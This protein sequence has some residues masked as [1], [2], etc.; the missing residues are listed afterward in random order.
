MSTIVHLPN[1]GKVTVPTDDPQEAAKAAQ[2]YWNQMGE[3][4][5]RSPPSS[6]PEGPKTRSVLQTAGDFVG[7]TIDNFLPNWGDEIA[8][9]PDAAAA[10]MRGQ[11]V[12]AAFDQGRADFRAN[13]AQYDKEHPWLAWGSTLTGLGASLALPAGR[14]ASGAGMAAKMA[15]GAAVGAGYGAVAGAGQGDTFDQRSGNAMTGALVGGVTGGAALPVLAG[16][17]GAVRAV[18]RTVPGAAAVGRTIRNV[19]RSVMR[20]PLHTRAQQDQDRANR[21]LAPRLNEGNIST[22]FGQQGPAASP[23]NLVDELR[24]RADIGVPAMLADTTETLRGVTSWASRGAGPGQTLVKEALSR[25]KEAEANRV[26]QH[27][28]DNLGDAVDPLAQMR[29]HESRA[30]AEV[31]PLYEEAYAQPVVV[32]DTLR[33]LHDTPAFRSAVPQAFENIQNAQ[34]NPF[35]MGFH[36]MPDGTVAAGPSMT[37]EAYDQIVRAMRDSGRRAGEVN[38]LT[39]K[40][41]DTT[42]SIHINERAADLRNELSAQNGAYRDAQNVYADE[43]GM[44][45][46]LDRGQAMPK[47]TGSEVRAI[48]EGLRGSARESWAIGARSALADSASTWGHEH[49]TGSTAAYV[50]RGLGDADKQQALEGLMG[51]D[52]NLPRLRDALEA[53]HQ[54]NITWGEVHGNSK[55]ALRQQLDADLDAAAGATR[56]SSW[57]MRGLA[58]RGFDAMAAGTTKRAQN[59]VK[60]HVGR[61]VTERDPDRLAAFMADIAD[62]AA[63]E[64][65]A[66]ETMRRGAVLGAKLAGRS[67]QAD[68]PGQYGA[69]SYDYNDDG[70]LGVQLIGGNY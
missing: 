29:A 43:L 21:F 6:A 48:G 54:G 22:G 25:R 70:T 28:T 61:V 49:P 40:V 47:Q 4:E 2:A 36:V 3:D 13:Q 52:A 64:E 26:R 69:G 12:G 41:R 51:P 5:R 59:A 65:A 56:P 62:L 58:A 11:D 27:V 15:H 37:T 20:R 67:V 63:R 38:P 55:T 9:L 50:R 16:A 17:R 39:G 33:K 7:D 32:N 45:D 53:E 35:E 57:T 24:R 60:E 44:R 14:V 34:R 30:R 18:E 8:A 66:S 46:A 42:N 31:R 19:P 23:D 68:Q 1:G 10:M